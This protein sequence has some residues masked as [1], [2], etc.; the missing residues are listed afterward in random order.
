MSEETTAVL[1]KRPGRLFFTDLDE[2]LLTTEKKVSEATYEAL[3]NYTEAGN[4]LVIAT[5]RS[6]HSALAVQKELGLDFPGSYILASN[7]CLIYDCD[8]RETLFRTGVP[9][10]LTAE[11]FK[12]AEEHGIYVQT[13]TD[14]RILAP[15]DCEE[16]RYYSRFVKTPVQTAKDPLPF[17]SEPPCK[18]LCISLHDH[19]KQ[20]RFRDAVT[21][22][23]GTEI[24][25]FYSSPYYLEI[26]PYGLGKGPAAMILADRLGVP[27]KCTMAAGDEGNDISMIKACGIGVAMCNGTE[28]CRKAADVITEKDN[29]HDGL[30]DLILRFTNGED[31]AFSS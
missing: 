4:S 21:A 17:L 13:Y 5:G 22:R 15:A 1:K 26:I 27:R 9:L 23:F 28:E 19:E 3:R 20:E 29:N 7:G 18:I 14:D 11:I 6:L 8:A 30:K 24:D 25:T 31:M 10:P 2:T 16:I 12:M